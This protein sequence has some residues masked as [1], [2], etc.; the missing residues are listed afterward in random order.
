MGGMM[1]RGMTPQMM[2]MARGNPA[3]MAQMMARGGM[4][5]GNPQVARAAQMAQMQAMELQRPVGKHAMMAE[6]C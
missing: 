2:A 6:F 5:G 1:G 4:K 3:M